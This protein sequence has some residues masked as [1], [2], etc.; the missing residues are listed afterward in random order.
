MSNE[1]Y[2][3]ASTK[4]L[5]E[6]AI[7]MERGAHKSFLYYSNH[8][9]RN[10]LQK[11]LQK[12]ATNEKMHLTMIM[13]L[14]KKRFRKEEILEESYEQGYFHPFLD[15]EKP[16]EDDDSILDSA[17]DFEI[18]AMKFYGILESRLAGVFREIVTYL[19]FFKEKHYFLLSLE[20]R[21]R[22]KN[23]QK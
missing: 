2:E 19:R 20:K 17:I 15:L 3:K 14:F 8:V 12:I 1:K 9:S 11:V 7:K 13:D 22:E 10:S 4:K 6:T 18:E 23:K 21:K 5:I 16:L